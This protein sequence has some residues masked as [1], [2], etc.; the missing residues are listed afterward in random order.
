MSAAET[1]GAGWRAGSLPRP[2]AAPPPT[3]QD[4][5]ALAERALAAAVGEGAATAAWEWALGEPEGALAV[6]LAVLR[7]GRVGFAAGGPD[8]LDELALV[9]Q[10]AV[11]DG[12]PGL[13]ELPAPAV[14]RPHQGYDP[15]VLRLDPAGLPGRWRAGAAK[16]AVVSSRGVRA[17]EQRSF[18]AVELDGLTAT[19]P[20]PAGVD[21]EPLAAEAA[22]LGEAGA[23]ADA[24]KAPP[25]ERPVVLGPDAVAAVLDRLRPAL[26]TAGGLAAGTRVT[27]SGINL[28]DSPRF[29]ATLPRSYDANGVPRQPVPLVQDGVAHRTVSAATGHALHPGRAEAA[30]R[31]LVLVGGGAADAEELMAPV[32]RGLYLPTLDRAFE[33]EHGRRGRPVALG[34][35]EVD[36]VA[37][38]ASTQALSARQRTIPTAGEARTIAATV[39]PA[40]R[41]TAGV[42]VS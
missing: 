30:P 19:A 27:A 40:L 35:L 42:R 24:P 22:E 38:L 3:E 20:G 9:A 36:P 41:A 39:A 32:E 26:G 34:A 28:S 14:G 6:E 11:A 12:P 29:G 5:V 2:V 18:A 23:I 1:P 15:G 16:V 25:G 7:D 17:F 10:R 13:G 8:A 21:A 37:V 4:L 31:H 33:I